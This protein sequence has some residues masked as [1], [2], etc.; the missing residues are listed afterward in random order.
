[1]LGFLV[2]SLS[3]EVEGLS[4]SDNTMR[5]RACFNRALDCI[6]H[7]HVLPWK[8]FMAATCCLSQGA[9]YFPNRNLSEFVSKKERISSPFPTQQ[10]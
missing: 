8:H 4:R 3:A 9:F 10:D 5:H 7:N 1:M 6:I 2:T